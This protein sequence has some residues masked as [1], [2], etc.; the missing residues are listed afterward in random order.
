MSTLV[1]AG[2]TDGIGKA[3][4]EVYLGRGDTVVVIGRSPEKGHRF[5]DAATA[6]GAA[7]RAF[8]VTADLSLLTETSRAAEEIR[9]A[10]PTVDAL[11]FCARHYRFRRTE[12]AEGYEE[13]FALFYLSR[14]VLGQ[15]LAEPLSRARHPVVVNVAGPGAGLDIVQ[16]DDLQFSRGYHGG[17]ALG[18]GGK[19]NDL[20]GVSYAEQHGPAGIRYVLIHPGVTA[21]GFSGEYDRATLAHIRSM[22]AHAKPV[23]AALPPI[24]DAID[25]PPAEALSAYVEGRRIPVDTPDFDPAAARRLRDLTDR[26]LAGS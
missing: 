16:W 22:Q 6:S 12:T 4:A 5:L 8:F 13:N 19:L 20:L 14:H 18:H 2:G 21:T 10:F 9:A 17:A 1:I 26:L 11:V 3:L 24:T 23:E 7:G 15:A 25:K